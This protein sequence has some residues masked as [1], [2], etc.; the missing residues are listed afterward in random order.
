MKMNVAPVCVKRMPTDIHS[1]AHVYT[2]CIVEI[3]RVILAMKCCQS[4]LSLLARNC[5]NDGSSLGLGGPPP[6]QSCSG[7]SKGCPLCARH[8]LRLVLD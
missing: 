6:K 8:T 5:T 4:V 3:V 2:I 1:L 7:T